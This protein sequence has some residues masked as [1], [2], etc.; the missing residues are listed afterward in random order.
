MITFC[1]SQIRDSFF[2]SPSNYF[3]SD[4]SID[5]TNAILLSPPTAPGDQFTYDDYGVPPQNC[6]PST[7][8]PF[9]WSPFVRIDRDGLERNTS[10]LEDLRKDGEGYLGIR[11]EI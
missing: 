10:R 7:P 3:D 9:K 4:I 5:S 11:V 1:F 8:E 2:L 6:L